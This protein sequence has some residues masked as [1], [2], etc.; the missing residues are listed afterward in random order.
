MHARVTTMT[1]DPE[2]LDE[3]VA[4]LEEE[5]L[6]RFSALDGFRGFTL[7]IERA[8]GKVTGTSYWSTREQM[9]AAEA[10]VSGLRRR[11][12]EIGRADAAPE[13]ER[14]EVAIDTFVR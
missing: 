13:V 12:A 3:A 8:S 1:L 7:L 5:D 14:F 4:R 11:T 2:R 6:P 9:D 10:E